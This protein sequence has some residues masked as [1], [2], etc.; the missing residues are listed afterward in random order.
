MRDRLRGMGDAIVTDWCQGRNAVG[1]GSLGTV[2]VKIWNLGSL[3]W[4]N[5]S[6]Y[7]GTRHGTSTTLGDLRL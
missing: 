2:C 5:G 3:L 6:W 1:A 4:P 7:E